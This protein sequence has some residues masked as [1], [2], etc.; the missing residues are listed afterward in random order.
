VIALNKT[1]LGPSL[2]EDGSNEWWVKH[3]LTSEFL[4][5]SL[6]A[7]ELEC[8]LERFSISKYLD[9]YDDCE[10]QDKQWLWDPGDSFTDIFLNYLEDIVSNPWHKIKYQL[11]LLVF[12]REDLTFIT[13]IP[14][15]MLHPP[16]EI[17]P[18]GRNS[19]S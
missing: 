11:Q 3:I 5:H 16:S 4:E 7:P 19:P 13:T 17:P 1:L 2:Y 14:W 6:W 12:I 15:N 9:C 8:A 18:V 10:E